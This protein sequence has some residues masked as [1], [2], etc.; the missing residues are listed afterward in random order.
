MN[1]GTVSALEVSERERERDETSLAVG[2]SIGDWLYVLL[3]TSTYFLL[4]ILIIIIISKKKSPKKEKG[5]VEIT[6]AALF[7]C[8]V[9]HTV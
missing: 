8:L 6:E 1:P 9:I 7:F 4:T 5:G 2:F 3:S